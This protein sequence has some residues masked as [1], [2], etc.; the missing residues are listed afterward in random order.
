[1]LMKYI[2]VQSVSQRAVKN[3]GGGQTHSAQCTGLLVVA[4]NVSKEPSAKPWL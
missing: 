3:T 1:M 2:V 4:T